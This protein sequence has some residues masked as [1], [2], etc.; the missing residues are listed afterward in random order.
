MPGEIAVTDIARLQDGYSA[1]RYTPLDVIEEVDRRIEAAG[2][3]HVWILRLSKEE[4]AR[5]AAELSGQ[6]A[7][8]AKLPLY[9]VPFAVKD[10]IDIKGLPTTAGCPDFAYV[11][12]QTAPVVQRLLDAGGILVGKTNLDQ[13]ATGLTGVRSP[14]GVPR[15]PY[16][17]DYI[18]GGSS[19]G[20]AVAVA[21]GLVSFALGTDTAGSIRVPAGFNNVVGLKP[22]RGLLSISGIVPACR[23]LDCVGILAMDTSCAEAVMDV[24]VAP[25]ATDADL[26]GM[27]TRRE[28]SAEEVTAAHLDRIAP[29]QHAE[30]QALINSSSRSCATRRCSAVVKRGSAA[31]SAP[32][33]S[34]AS[35]DHS[36]SPRTAIATNVRW[37]SSVG[38]QP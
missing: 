19:S 11:A 4:M 31:S 34:S 17:K 10:N 35:R 15:N 23:S 21:S 38:R 27:L 3:D 1:A 22:T 14:Y 32:P 18:P 8:A 36:S 13:F 7:A 33:I 2:D 5:R 20:S 9:G 24:A 26:A 6:R 30:V 37:P 12:K 25:D 29:E 16:N 28:V